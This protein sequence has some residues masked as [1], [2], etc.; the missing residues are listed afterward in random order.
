MGCNGK[1][2]EK[3]EKLVQIRKIFSV[4]PRFFAFVL[5]AVAD[6][7]AETGGF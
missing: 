3:P 6:K 2:P 7:A 1:N 5:R 4:G